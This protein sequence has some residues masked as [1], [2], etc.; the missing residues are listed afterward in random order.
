MAVSDSLFTLDKQLEASIT[1]KNTGK[2]TGKET[3][4]LYIRDLTAS[5]T[6]PIK[7]L[8]GFEQVS[9]N[10]GEEKKIVFKL[11]NEEL[12]FELKNKGWIVE[13]GKFDIMIGVNSR[14]LTSKRVELIK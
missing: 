11:S 2:Y 6:R 5:I 1:I 14:D 12:G 3:V 10:P 7:E 9:L 4:Q 13:P 8:R